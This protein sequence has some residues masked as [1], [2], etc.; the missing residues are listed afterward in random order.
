V[1]GQTIGHYRVLEQIG[2]G[3][4]G[5]VYRAEDLRLG[6]HVALKLLPTDLEASPDAL[7]RF[8][9]EAELI[10]SLNHPHICTLHDLGEHE[11]RRFL[12]FELVDGQTLRQRL[13]HGPIP[14]DEA[15]AIAVD[16]ADA[17]DAAHGR[18]IVHR[19]VKPGNIMLTARGDA[20][21]LDFG[22][23]KRD[24][25]TASAA[26]ETRAAVTRLGDWIGTPDY[27]APEQ[28]QGEGIDA[29]TDLFALGAVMYEMVTGCAP[30]TATSMAGAID[31]VLHRE[32]VPP[33]TTNAA[34]PAAFDAVILKA[35]EK[36]RAL[37]YQTARDLVADLRR[38]AVLVSAEP[39]AAPS[40]RPTGRPWLVM[41][42]VG[43]LLL[44]ALAAWLLWS[45][46]QPGS[47]ATDGAVARL[48]VL[49]FE[50]QTGQSADDW[51]SYAF[52]DA[53]G[54]ALQ[55]VAS[56]IL[57]PRERVVELYKAEARREFQ[58]L[59]SELTRQISQKLRVRYYVHGSYQ[60]VGED[61]RVTARLVDVEA[62]SVRWQA[63]LTDK[64][65]RVL[66]LEDALAGRVAAEL[67]S[68]IAGARVGGTADL[69]AL[70]WFT[71]AGTFYFETNYVGARRLLEQA[72][73]R[74]GNYA[75]AWALL[76]KTLSRLAAPGAAGTEGAL[77]STEPALDAAQKAV[78]LAPD[79]A[80]SHIALAL[81]YR[82]SKQRNQMMD[83]IARAASL[84]PRSAE[85]LALMGDALSIA[86]GF[87]C[88]TGASPEIAEARYREALRLD[89]LSTAYSNLLTSLWWM[90]RPV[91]ALVVVDEGLAAQPNNVGIRT[92]RPFNLAFAGRVAEADAMLQATAGAPMTGQDKFIRAMVALKAGRATEADALLRQIDDL[93]QKILAFR[94]IAA[95]AQFQAGRAAEGAAHLAKAIATEPDCRDWARTVPALAP[96]RQTPQFVQ[97]VGGS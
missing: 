9:R 30:F 26:G 69:Q 35:L 28:A 61:L 17:L 60:R 75:E 33:S 62:D 2:R 64:F 22:I 52:S 11:G 10:S 56:I 58:A 90:D 23:A 84:A 42:S 3:G 82:G 97:A 25:P 66:A 1:I 76:S 34:V 68:S 8:R 74:D 94:L 44:V 16:I 55:P 40:I 24:W 95:V 93:I 38:V 21:L 15:L 41:A 63:P 71:E 27:M 70:R 78:R 73:V 29:R 14:V 80:E 91:D 50:N 43:T 79:L 54:A 83:A 85:P 59:S 6:R 65:A 77:D 37:R 48:V 31:A 92:W 12:V 13:G 81:A 32:P 51:L 19:D 7:E 39:H 46:R 96:F 67:G 87:G 4:M 72:V 20:K 57:V 86:P 45:G 89:P 49:P 47:A 18:G 88:P 53:I 5:L 36:D